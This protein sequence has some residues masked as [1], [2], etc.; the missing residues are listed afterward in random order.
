M[1]GVLCI[2]RSARGGLADRRRIVGGGGVGSWGGG[3]GGEG[4]GAEAVGEGGV[5]A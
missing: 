1:H 2:G 5:A 3:R 4:A